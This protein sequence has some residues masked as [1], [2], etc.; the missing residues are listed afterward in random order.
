MLMSNHPNR[1]FLPNHLNGNTDL[2]WAGVRNWGP[3]YVTENGRTIREQVYFKEAINVNGHRPMHTAMQ[4]ANAEMVEWLLDQGA[5]LNVTDN[6][7]DTPLSMLGRHVGD[8]VRPGQTPDSMMRATVDVVCEHF[9]QKWKIRMFE[10]RRERLNAVMMSFLTRGTMGGVR[11]ADLPSDVKRKL[12][13]FF[14]DATWTPAHGGAYPSAVP[15]V[16]LAGTV[17]TVLMATLG[18]GAYR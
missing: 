14:E 9:V 2:H 7:G 8:W 12:K 17:V 18:S 5:R 13:A 1:H 15:W 10:G 3:D 4:G 16:A 11:T 6:R